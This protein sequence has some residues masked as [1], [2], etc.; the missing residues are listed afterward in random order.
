[1]SETDEQP[2][3][4]QSGLEEPLCPAV[5]SVS[6]I[7]ASEG[8]VTTADVSCTSVTALDNRPTCSDNEARCAGPSYETISKLS[9]LKSSPSCTTE[10][11]EIGN[12]EMFSQEEAEVCVAKDCTVTAEGTKDENS[13]GT[14]FSTTQRENLTQC[15]DSVGSITQTSQQDSGEIER[16]SNIIVPSETVSESTLCSRNE[17]VSATETMETAGGEAA[18]GASGSH[19][20]PSQCPAPAEDI[21]AESATAVQ[22][23]M[24]AEYDVEPAVYADSSYCLA[25]T[26]VPQFLAEARKEFEEGSG[27]NFLRGCKW[28]PDGSCI[29]TNSND[30]RL[31]LYSVVHDQDTSMTP[32]FVLKEGSQIYDFA[33]LP[34]MSSAVPESN[35]LACTCSSIPVHLWNTSTGE[36]QA[37]Y[38]AYDQYDEVT[39]A[40]SLGFSLDGRKLYAGYDK[41][42]RIFDTEY[43]VRSCKTIKTFDSKRKEGQSGIISCFAVSP[44]NNGFFVA[45]SYSRHIGIY[46]TSCDRLVCLMQGQRGGITHVMFSPD[47]TKLYSGGRK[48]AEILCWDM[49]NTGKILFSVLRDV[50][51][52]QRMYFDL[53]QSGRY[54]TT[55]NH[56]GSVAFWDTLLPGEEVNGEVFLKPCSQFQA[57]EDCVNGVSLNHQHGILATASGQRHFNNFQNYDSDETDD[58]MDAEEVRDFSLKLWSLSASSQS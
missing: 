41:V 37:S 30:N 27:D 47:G 2:V 11:N 46:D 10:V 3:I 18:A 24:M 7:V 36:R 1:M 38:R 17:D 40:Y 12:V 32:S 33:W 8:F 52:N 14:L 15:H 26:C 56:D 9:E 54:L 25:R 35:R 20:Q 29:V 13:A 23:H 49:R 31:R 4:L 42:I 5:T 22:D 28:S 51:T 34:Q 19:P 16:E 55:G 58:E 50:K 6:P 53:S 43:P 44:D 39:A 45:G 21:P 57:H 48:D